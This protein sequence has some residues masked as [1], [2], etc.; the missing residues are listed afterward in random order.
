MEKPLGLVLYKGE[1]L[2]DGKMIVVLATGFKGKT[3][4]KKTGNMIQTWIVRADIPPII[5]KQ[6]GHDY[7][8]CGDCK[9]R[10]FGSCYVNITHGPDNTFKA[11]HRDR[12]EKFEEEKHLHLFKG[13]SIRIGSYGDPASVPV[14][15]WQ[16]VCSVADGHTGYTHQ[17]NKRFIEP[18]LKTYCMASC[19]NEKEYRKAKSLGWRSFR[20]RFDGNQK[21]LDN[22]FVCPASNEAH[23][24]TTCENCQA[25]MGLG[26]HTKKDPCIIV[27]GLEHKI[28]A[29]KWGMTRIAWKEAYRKTFSYPLKKKKIRKKRKLPA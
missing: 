22:E 6:L 5:A 17:W 27:H 21:L 12:Y 28:K 4:N 2:I 7:S 15:V 24:K 20:V 14:A 13:R 8:V 1:S 26:S 19:D 18:E 29:F 9:H 25:C 3:A 23:N 11:Y 16:K 10:H